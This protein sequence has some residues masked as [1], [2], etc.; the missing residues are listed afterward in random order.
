MKAAH[1][2]AYERFIGPIPENLLVCH[3]CD[4][5][6]CVNPNHLFLGTIKDNNQD[7]HRKGG[8][9]PKGLS[10][11]VIFTELDPKCYKLD[12]II[13]ILNDY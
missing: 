6:K 12:E 13:E 8:Y 5:R 9:K 4:N 3:K 7:R 11:S 2:F 10:T 1:R